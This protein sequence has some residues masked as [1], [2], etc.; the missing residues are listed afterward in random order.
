MRYGSYFITDASVAY[1]FDSGVGF[2]LG[3]DNLFNRGLP[4]STT[5]TGAGSAIYDNIG[6]FAYL[7]ATYRF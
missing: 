3:V 2:K 1:K 5:G 6:R 7:Q 4:G